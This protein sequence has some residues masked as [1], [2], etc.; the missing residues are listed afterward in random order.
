[1]SKARWF[2]VRKQST[3]EII[4]K[5]ANQIVLLKFCG[6]KKCNQTFLSS[7]RV[8]RVSGNETIHV[9]PAYAS[10]RTHLWCKHLP[11]QWSIRINNCHYWCWLKTRAMRSF[12]SC[13][14]L[15]PGKLV[16]ASLTSNS[17]IHNGR[18]NSLFSGLHDLQ[19]VM[20]GARLSSKFFI[21]P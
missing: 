16:C 4:A 9:Y 17:Y 2:V 21:K 14:H 10:H 18:Q 13:V 19:C 11:L 20:M 15:V 12:P 3:G 7:P 5:S 1:M 8:E 6:G